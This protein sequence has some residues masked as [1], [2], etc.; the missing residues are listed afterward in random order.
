EFM[1]YWRAQPGLTGPDVAHYGQ[2]GA[3]VVATAVE[4][5][6]AAADPVQGE[7]WAPP[8]RLAFAAHQHEGDAPEPPP[9]RA[10]AGN[11]AGEFDAACAGAAATVDSTYLTPYEMSMPME[12]HACLAVPRGKELTLYVSTQVVDGVRA[13][14]ART[15]Q[16]TP[17][18]VHVVAPYVGGGF[19][20]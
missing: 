20:S 4:Q 18:H 15:L 7:D 12:P 16:M 8:G 17:E 9:G 3:P 13:G 6:R 1:E 14:V 10:P 19:G 11:R 5:G 2:P